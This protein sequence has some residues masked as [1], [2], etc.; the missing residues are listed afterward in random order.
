MSHQLP[1]ASPQFVPFSHPLLFSP[2]YSVP[3]LPHPFVAPSFPSPSSSSSSSSC[4][5]VSSST[6]VESDCSTSSSSGAATPITPTP[7]PPQQMVRQIGTLAVPCQQNSQL[8]RPNTTDNR[9]MANCATLVEHGSKVSIELTNKELW[10]KFHRVTNEMVVT[11]TGRKMFPKLELR[12]RGLDPKGMYSLSLFM[13]Q[14]DNFRYKYQTGGWSPAG[15]DEAAASQSNEVQHHDGTCSGEFWTSQEKLCFDRVKLT[16][17]EV[18]SN[19]LV[20]LCSM[21]KYQPVVSLFRLVDHQ[22]MHLCSF[23]PPETQFIAVT[24]YQCEAITRLKVEHNPFAKGFREGSSRK[25]TL[26]PS[27]ISA[28]PSGDAPSPIGCPSAKRSFLCPS[29][30]FGPPSAVPFPLH[31]PLY[32]SVPSAWP[33]SLSAFLSSMA[34]SSLNCSFAGAYQQQNS[35]IAELRKM[36]GEIWKNYQQKNRDEDGDKEEGQQ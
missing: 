33:N 17:R 12:L 7:H 6:I 2:Y 32:G 28:G 34:N 8:P 9:T 35:Q 18:H 26:S 13:R 19:S 31:F 36:Y 25:R 1:H 11:R 23:E 3:C 10:Q 30:L 27:P 5:T 22:A 14:L 20:S 16:N 24:A 29:S 15:Q 21:H 4:N